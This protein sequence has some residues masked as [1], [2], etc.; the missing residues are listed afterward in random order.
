MT[1][2]VHVRRGSVVE[3]VHRGA[4]AVA[5]ADGRVIAGWGDGDTV[6]YP[7]SSLKPFQA[8][9]IA[10]SGALEAFGLGDR[11]LALAAASHKGEAIHTGM[12]AEW[13]QRL[14]LTEDALACGPDLPG[15][16]EAAERLLAAGGRR[17]RIHHNCSGKHCGFLTFARHLGAPVSGYNEVAHPVQQA[18]L[19]AFSEFL[20]YEARSLDWARDGCTLP[21]LALKVAD[22]ARALARFAATRTGST[23]RTAAARRVQEA[24][25]ALPELVSGT[26]DNLPKLV[27]A[28]GGRVLAKGGAEGYMAAFV[29]DQGLG[30]AIKIADGQ[31][32]AAWPVLIA[33]LERLKLL[34]AGEADALAAVARPAVRDSVG[35]EVG[36]IEARLE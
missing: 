25:R 31:Q 29:P 21:A 13:L 7:R 32:R 33:V 35:V 8:T 3:S 23:T 1:T 14:G 24:M 27:A 18:Y 19:D 11:H 10:E 26:A 17:T 2:L 9:A 16:R 28:T 36:R 4:V 5:T 30:I 34:Q 6:A 20:G 12:V 15:D 22:M